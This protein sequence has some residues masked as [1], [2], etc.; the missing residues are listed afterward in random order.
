[1]KFFSPPEHGEQAAK[2]CYIMSKKTRLK[3]K[4]KTSPGEK[5]V[6]LVAICTFV[7]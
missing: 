3:K 6:A 2:I 1:V 5:G 7:P 4:T